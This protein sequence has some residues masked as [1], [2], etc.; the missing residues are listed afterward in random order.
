MQQNQE[1]KLMKIKL[2]PN[3]KNKL[4]TKITSKGKETKKTVCLIK[5]SNVDKQKRSCT[6]CK[7]TSK[8]SRMDCIV[9]S[10]WCGGFPN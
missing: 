2:D 8:E 5:G 7:G 3:R 9:H 4:E 10:K 6:V 1:K